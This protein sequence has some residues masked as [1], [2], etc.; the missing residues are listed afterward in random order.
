M[1]MAFSM[2]K[3]DFKRY[4]AKKMKKSLFRSYSAYNFKEFLMM[5]CH[6]VSV[7]SKKITVKKNNHQPQKLQM[8]DILIPGALLS[9]FV[10][11]ADEKTKKIIEESQKKQDEALKRKEINEEELRKVVQR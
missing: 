11:E 7:H 5:L 10:I 1:I 2:E 6:A 4:S 3:L 9:A 8:N